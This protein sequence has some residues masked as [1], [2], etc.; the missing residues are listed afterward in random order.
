M[1]PAPI[2]SL[3]ET[4]ER[5]DALMMRHVDALPA[6]AETIDTVRPEAFAARFAQEVRW[7]TEQMQPHIEAVESSLYPQLERLMQNRHSMLPM[8]H[9]HGELRRMIASLGTYC[10]VAL[11]TGLAEAEQ[12][13]LRRALYRLHAILK[14]HLAEEADYRDVLERNLSPEERD[15]LARSLDHAMIEPV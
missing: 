15:A 3:P 7:L 6:L 14:V 5:H 4:S 12:V 10:D 13:G 1:D 9:E 8:R 11:G 2:R